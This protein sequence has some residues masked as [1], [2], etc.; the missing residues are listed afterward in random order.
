MFKGTAGRAVPQRADREETRR[1]I[2][3]TALALFRQRG[4]EAT[5]RLAAG[6]AGSR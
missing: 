1:Q 6:K 2:L 5:T 4:F 3:E